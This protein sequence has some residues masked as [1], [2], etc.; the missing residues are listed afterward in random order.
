MYGIL[1]I[2]KNSLYFCTNTE[3]NAARFGNEDVASYAVFSLDDPPGSGTIAISMFVRTRRSNGLLLVLANSTSQYLHLWLDDGR[4]KFQVNNLESLSGRVVVSDG[5]FHLVTVR[6]EGDFVTLFQSAHSQGTIPIRPVV[7]QPGDLVYVGGLA[8][9]RA[10]ASFGGYLK[11][12]VQ[13]LRINSKRLQFFPIATPV[14][15]YGL[16]EL[17]NVTKGCTSDNACSVSS[18]IY[19]IQYTYRYFATTQ[20]RH[21]NTSF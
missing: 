7:A 5:H 21:D 6:L 20:L 10:S 15:S 16:V 2:V 18:W 19:S 9:Q 11:G 8:D 4:V 14:A 17:V 1:L 13:D 12:C 3:Y